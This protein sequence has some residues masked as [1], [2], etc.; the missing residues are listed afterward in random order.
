[1]N[2]NESAAENTDFELET[3]RQIPALN[4]KRYA[5]RKAFLL[6]DENDEEKHVSYKQFYSQTKRLC[7]GLCR[8]LGGNDKKIAVCMKNCYEWCVS[9]FAVVCGAGVVVPV[10]REIPIEEFLNTV[11]FAHIDAVITDEKFAGT[12]EK[13]AKHLPK[14]FKIISCSRTAGKHVISLDSLIQCGKQM[15]A[16]GKYK[17]KEIDPDA[18]AVLLFTSGTTGMAKAVMLSNR[19]ICSDITGVLSVVDVDYNDSTLCVLPLHHTYQSIVMLVTLYIGGCVSFSEN[20]RNVSKDMKRFRP[21]I[22][23][24]VPLLLEKTHNKIMRKLNEQS[25]LKKSLTVGKASQV[26]SKIPGSEIKKKLYSLIH[27]AFGGNMRLIITGAAAINEDIV[28]DYEAFGFKVIIGYGLTECSPIAICNSSEDPRP[29]SIGKP[30]QGAEIKIENSTEDGIGEICVRGPMVMLGYYKNKKATDDVI[31]DGW[32]HTG[33][34]GFCDDEGYYHITGRSKNVIIAKNGKNVYPEEL[35]YYLNRDPMVLESLIFSDDEE[36]EQVTAC[37]VP[38][39]EAIKNELQ[40]EKLSKED[41]QNAILQTVRKINRALPSYKNIRKIRIH[42]NELEK[43][44]TSKIRRNSKNNKGKDRQTLCENE[45][46]EKNSQNDEPEDK[47]N[48]EK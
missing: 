44:N 6:A 4:S 35:E 2:E 18:P 23:A 29:D 17:E 19:N 27:E 10:D 46:D 41:I 40:K 37:V 25:F 15:I 16:D 42:E 30:I 9:Y 5:I 32:L 34:L 20:L 33:D 36:D 48:E 43:T 11:R 12:L 8:L 26:L 47:N 28:R 45:N 22:F 38:D 7:A 31:I 14:R 13:N 3:L 1:M 39:E 21:T 24:C